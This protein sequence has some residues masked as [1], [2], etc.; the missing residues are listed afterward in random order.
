MPGFAL[1][2]DTS[3]GTLFAGVLGCTTSMSGVEATIETKLKS[4]SESYGSFEYS[5]TLIACVVMSCSQ[6]L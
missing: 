5:A 1:R 2:S 6:M 4:C 3:S